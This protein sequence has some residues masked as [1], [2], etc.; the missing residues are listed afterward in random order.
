[1]SEI[2]GSQTRR[3]PAHLAGPSPQ[4]CEIIAAYNDKVWR[5]ITAEIAWAADFVNVCPWL[6][7]SSVILLDVAKGAKLDGG[8]PLPGYFV[9]RL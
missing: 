6:C 7:A 1:M 5:H 8:P 3:E 2:T 4:R 9:T